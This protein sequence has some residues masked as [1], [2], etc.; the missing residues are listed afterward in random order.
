MDRPMRIRLHND[1]YLTKPIPLATIN[2]AKWAYRT[3]RSVGATPYEARVRAGYS[4]FMDEVL[5][6]PIKKGST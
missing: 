4:I 1:H 6:Q 2:R 5:D 3:W